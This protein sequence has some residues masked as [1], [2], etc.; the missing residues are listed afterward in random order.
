MVSRRVLRPFLVAALG[1]ALVL[2]FASA[3]FASSVQSPVKVTVR[4]S[5]YSIPAANLLT[6]GGSAVNTPTVAAWIWQIAR[7]TNSSPVSATRKLNAS[8]HTFTFKAYRKG[9]PLNQSAAVTPVVAELNSELNGGSAKTIALPYSTTNPKVTKFGVAVITSLS[10]RK[11]YL[12]S[13]TKLVKTYNCAIG[14]AQYPTPTGTFYIGKKVKNPSWTNSGAAWAKGMPS[15]IGPGPNN[16]LG[17]RALYVYGKSGD[18]GV[19]FHGVPSSESSS[20]G[21]ASS[22]GCMRM[23]RKDVEDF[24][25]R[26]PVDSPVYIVK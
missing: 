3:A 20:I 21:H 19:R 1:V 17:T 24:Y 10:K 15:Y 2:A 23:Q 6:G 5:S 9:Y 18:T 14:K 13:N 22:H 26:V 8:K 4:G 16:P 7:A 12:W 25:P 11:I